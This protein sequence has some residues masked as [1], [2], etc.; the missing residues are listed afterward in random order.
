M[1]KQF[2][3]LLLIFLFLSII[4]Y[5][6]CHYPTIQPI[7]N[8]ADKT[9]E[10][11]FILKDRTFIYDKDKITITPENTFTAPL[12]KAIVS[13]LSDLKYNYTFYDWNGII[14]ITYNDIPIKIN[15]NNYSYTIEIKKSKKFEDT[16]NIFIYN[17]ICGSIKNNI[18]KTTSP[19]IYENVAVVGC[20]FLAYLIYR[21]VEDFNSKDYDKFYSSPISIES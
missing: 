14:E 5:F 16:L 19:E 9:N 12:Q 13:K 21:G 18:L 20:I 4:Y 17:K 11:S 2:S 3:L 1:I 8:F 15:V 10:K 6:S 7:E